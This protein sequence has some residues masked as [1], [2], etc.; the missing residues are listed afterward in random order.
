MLDKFNNLWYYTNMTELDKCGIW[1][2][3]KDGSLT[4]LVDKS[5]SEIIV[6]NGS[7]P[8]YNEYARDGPLLRILNKLVAVLKGDN[9]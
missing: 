2:Q 9:T 7:D 8:G 1:K 6:D 3:E 4:N 5:N